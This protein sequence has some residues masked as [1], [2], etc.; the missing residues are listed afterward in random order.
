MVGITGGIV[1]C[2]FS[3]SLAVG[4][5]IDFL[6][7]STFGYLPVIDSLW[8]VGTVVFPNLLSIGVVTGFV[9]GTVGFLSGL[10][11]MGGPVGNFLPPI[12]RPVGF[13]SAN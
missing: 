7:G 8:F 9:I 6:L 12:D 4:V 5:V 3:A 11:V 2:F 13:L 10:V 1:V